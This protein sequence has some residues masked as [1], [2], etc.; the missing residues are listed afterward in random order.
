MLLRLRPVLRLLALAA[1]LGGGPATAQADKASAP[2]PPATLALIK[3]RG[4]SPE[5]PILLRAYKKDSE[6]EVWKRAGNG[7]FVFIKTYPIC[8]WSGQLGPKTK[9]GD[10]QTPEGFYTVAKS[11]MNPN[12][13]YYLSFDVGYPNAY[14]KAHGYTGS[15]VM[16]HGIC[17]SMG[18]FAMTDTVAGELFAVAREAFAG[19]QA[20]FQ[21][22]SFPFRMSAANMARYRS[23]PNIA[24]WRQLKEGSDRFEATGQEPVA[25]VTAGR[26]A[27]VPLKD[28]DQ[29]ALATARVKEEAVHVAGLVEDGAAAIRTTYSDGGQHPFWAAL[30]SR[31]VPV[32][33]VS[34]PEA[35]AYAGQEVVLIPARRKTPPIAPLPD[36]V[37]T[38]AIASGTPFA[39]V[40]TRDF[41]PSYEAP[42]P[43][44]VF[45]IAS[46]EATRLPLIL[47]G[48]RDGSITPPDLAGARPLVDVVAQR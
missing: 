46:N 14:D 4:S 33:E 26:Y 36:A 31:G 5:A 39:S 15:A 1:C 28:R 12:S 7:R 16:V 38:A 19:G 37:W 22:Q 17:S 41:I 27:F 6:I 18:C 2:I 23:D 30:I 13:H 20:A 8:R 34:R 10:R 9:T 47:R 45:E 44:F 35:L 25:T 40:R 21:F 3:A 42:A 29:E 11:Q 32:G 48:A 43:R 24:F